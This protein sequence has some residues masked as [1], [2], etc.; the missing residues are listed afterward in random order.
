VNGCP[1]L[2]ASWARSSS[3]CRGTALY[4]H[5]LAEGAGRRF[6]PVQL[7]ASAGVDAHG[8]HAPAV[9]RVPALGPSLCVP[10]RREGC[11]QGV[12][13]WIQRCA[14]AAH[15]SPSLAP[16]LDS[17]RSRGYAAAREFSLCGVTRPRNTGP[18]CLSALARSEKERALDAHPQPGPRSTAATPATPRER[19]A[20]PGVDRAGDIRSLP[21]ADRKSA[22]ILPSSREHQGNGTDIGVGVVPLS[23]WTNV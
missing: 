12:A 5:C 15:P 9:A 4:G 11:R 3:H 17:P 6:R 19:N 22:P 16:A 10:T 7:A 2:Q 23:S 13:S 20:R 18:L 14:T 21:T 1:R 8:S